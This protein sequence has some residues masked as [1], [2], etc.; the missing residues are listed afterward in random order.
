MFHAVVATLDPDGG[1]TST[2]E[3][4]R[5]LPARAANIEC[6]DLPAKELFDL[7]DESEIGGVVAFGSPWELV[8][9]GIVRYWIFGDDLH[10]LSRNQKTDL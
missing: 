7:F 8:V 4:D 2:V 5:Q 10:L 9:R 3:I 6:P 1:M